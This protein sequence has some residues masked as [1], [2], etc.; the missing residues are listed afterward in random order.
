M[1]ILCGTSGEVLLDGKEE[2]LPTASS[3]LNSS[4][5]LCFVKQISI[6]PLIFFFKATTNS[7]LLKIQGVYVFHVSENKRPPR[8][9]NGLEMKSLHQ[10]RHGLHVD[11]VIS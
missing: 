3:S 4:L 2:I 1:K 5:Q 8:G 9:T 11:M 7:S 10:F 6:K